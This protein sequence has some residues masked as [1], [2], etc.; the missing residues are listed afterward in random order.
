MFATV[1]N[2]TVGSNGSLNYTGD[3]SQVSNIIQIQSFY[4]V[5]TSIYRP[6]RYTTCIDWIERLYFLY[7]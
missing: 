7:Y 2:T 5:D 3:E 1:S 6:K 4:E